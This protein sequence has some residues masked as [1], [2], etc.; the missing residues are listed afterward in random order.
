MIQDGNTPLFMASY[1]GNVKIVQLLLQHGANVHI[2]CKVRKTVLYCT[3]IEIILYWTQ[4]H[5]LLLNRN[6][7]VRM[8]IAWSFL[9]VVYWHHVCCV[10]I[11]SVYIVVIQDGQTALMFA[12]RNGHGEIVELLLQHGADLNVHAKVRNVVALQ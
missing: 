10:C 11:Y 4:Q 2:Q 6:I 1:S 7:I 9:Y 5:M 12:S 8:W 3:V